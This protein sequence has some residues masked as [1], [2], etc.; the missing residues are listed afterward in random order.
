M[1]ESV[2]LRP[3]TAD[4]AFPV[5]RWSVV[6]RA[7]EGD[8]AEAREALEDL[9]RRYWYPLYGFARRRGLPAPDAEDAVQ[10][11][12]LSLLE[13]ESL[14]AADRDL[15]RLRSFFLG[16]FTRFLAQ[17]WR[18]AHARK[19]GGG[20]EVVSMDV[21]W[22]ESQL[23]VD[24]GEGKNLED[25][26]DRSWA[27]ALLGRVF[28]RLEGHYAGRDNR[29]VFVQL[30]HC[31]LGDGDYGGQDEVARRLGLSPA[32]VRS[33]V[34]QMRQRFRRYVEEE[35]RETVGGEEEIGAELAHLCRI[36]S[37]G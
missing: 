20:C 32:G 30:K 15:G 7:Q 21:G 17:Q 1:D 13:R 25:T 36:L 3:G 18:N 5:T 33:A 28:E 4:R 16:A 2:S 19:R 9:C 12:F 10:A 14:H 23:A 35:I 22:A 29:E 6:L 26:F 27:H 37:D 8:P 34:F 31:L 11:F 24:A